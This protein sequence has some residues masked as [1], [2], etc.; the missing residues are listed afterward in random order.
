M[1]FTPEDAGVPL[2]CPP[3]IAMEPQE[4]GALNPNADADRPPLPNMKGSPQRVQ[5]AGPKGDIATPKIRPNFNKLD[6][7]TECQQLKRIRQ[8]QEQLQQLERALEMS[9]QE[10]AVQLCKLKG[11]V[12]ALFDIIANATTEDSKREAD[13]HPQELDR[14]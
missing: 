14:Q 3:T 5:L 6:L 10:L 9:N 4:A 7:E 11:T 12:E 1:H 8:D 13:S 2:D